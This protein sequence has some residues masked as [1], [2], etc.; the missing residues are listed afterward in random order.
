MFKG[1]LKSASLKQANSNASYIYAG[2][3]KI[4]MFKIKNCYWVFCKYT[5]ANR[6]SCTLVKY[7]YSA[8]CFQCHKAGNVWGQA[9]TA[10]PSKFF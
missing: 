9:N 3:T 6:Y 7:K 5:E 2:K 10:F 1:Q 4:W 8:E